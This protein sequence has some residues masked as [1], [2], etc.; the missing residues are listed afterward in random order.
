MKI[1]I[2]VLN[3]NGDKFISKC[4]DSL[5]RLEVGSNKVEVVVVD[6]A[7]SDNSVNMLLKQ[8]P[9]WHLIENKENLGYAEGNNVGIRYALS[10]N[11]DWIWIVNPDVYVDPKSLEKL[12]SVA[13]KY[14][15]AGILSSKVYFSP[16]FEFEK[17][18]YKKSEIGKVLWFGGGRMDWNNVYA[19]HLGMNEVDSGQYD[20]ISQTELATGA[21]MLLNA[22]ML[23]DVGL[24]DSKFFLYYEENDLCQR[25]RRENW[26]LWY[27]PQSIAWHANAQSTVT[28]SNLVDYYTTRNRMLF[29]MRWAPL[30]S[31]LALLRESLRLI[32]SGRPWQ[33]RGILDFYLGRFGQGSYA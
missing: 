6:N 31:K 19:V 21:S 9:Q 3:W 29:G 13:T 1:V 12:L 33:K 24:L 27:V 32:F 8:Y 26:E 25:V 11:A 23:N 7:S 2:V 4:L 14:P 15:N 22:Q 5:K 20:Q 30:K 28:G 16:G 18:K 17:D 10:T